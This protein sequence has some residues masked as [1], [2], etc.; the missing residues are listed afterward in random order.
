MNSV[1]IHSEVFNPCYLRRLEDQTPTQIFY[2]GASSG[3]SFFAVGQRVVYDLLKGGRNYLI[4]RQ[5]ARTIKNSVYNEVTKTIKAWGV[6]G[7]FRINKSEFTITCNNGYQILFAGL[8]DVEKIK[9]ITPEKGVLTDVVIEEATE[10]ER[11]SIKQLEKRLRGGSEAIQKRI[12]ILFNPIIK[13]HWIYEDYF[14]TIGWADTQTEYHDENLSI[15]KTTHKDNNFLTA[16]DHAKLENEKDEYFYNV[17]TLGNWGVLGDVIFKNV[18]IANLNDPTDK[19]YLPEAHRTNR[20]NGLDF[21]FSSDPA[22]MPMIHLDKMR[23]RIYIFDELYERGLTN[24]ELALFVKEKIGTDYVTCDSAEPKSI[25]ELNLAGVNAIGAKKGKDSINF[26]IQW[27]QGY[28]IIID[29]TCVNAQR[30]FT[31]YHWKKNKDGDSMRI[32]VDRD[33]HLIDGLRY[34]LEDDMLESESVAVNDPTNNW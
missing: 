20:R 32:P 5:V 1:E 6:Q 24:Q 9:S 27:L 15:L 28:D 12:T 13:T 23:K 26:G 4:C 21:G 16:Q 11:E 33:N 34:A 2:G 30:E 10:T 25:H 8:D 17:Y 29:V 31:T 7:L 18:H 22:A 14:A 19:Y 3:K